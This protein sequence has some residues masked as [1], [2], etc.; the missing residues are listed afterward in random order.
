MYRTS[1]KKL[2]YKPKEG[3]LRAKWLE[4]LKLEKELKAPTQF[5]KIN[6]GK[7]YR[8]VAKR[9]FLKNYPMTIT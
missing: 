3:T 4:K 1:L 9:Y 2:M 8:T 5:A 6:I 7:C